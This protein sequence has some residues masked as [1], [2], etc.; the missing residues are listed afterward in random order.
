MYNFNCKL[1]RSFFLSNGRLF[2]DEND[3][4]IFEI[5]L[6]F[7]RSLSVIITALLVIKP[8]SIQS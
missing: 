5:S 1:Y 4:R 3:V 2:T 8:S 7:Q 6:V